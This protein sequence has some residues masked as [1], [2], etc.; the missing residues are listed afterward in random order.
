MLEIY[1]SIKNNK[2]YNS[3]IIFKNNNTINGSSL[4]D[5]NKYYFFEH[6]NNSEY[7]QIIFFRY[8]FSL[9]YKLIK[10]EYFIAFYDKDNNLIL[11]SDFSLYKNMNIICTTTNNNNV[12]DSLANIYKNKYFNCIEIF[13]INEKIKFGIKIIQTIKKKQILEHYF[14]EKLF[15]FNNLNYQ[16]NSPFDPLIINVEY[17]SLISKMN[18]K[19]FNQTLILKKSYMK[20]PSFSLKVEMSSFDN[21]W[22]FRNIYNHHFCFCKGNNCLNVKM[23]EKCKYNFYLYI[24]DINQKVYPKTEYLFMDFIFDELSSDDVYPIFEEMINQH[25]PA[26]YVT[27]KSNLY[28]KFC[29]NIKNC[30]IVL[31]VKQEKNPLNS[32]FLEKYLILFLKIKVVISGRGTTFNTNLFY[33]IEYI[34][35]ICVG[36]GVC[37]FK[38]FLYNNN[39][40]YGS[41]KSCSSSRYYYFYF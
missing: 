35:Y 7:Y 25:F 19:S 31:P 16:Y 37:Y 17:N 6:L 8:I 9:K 40:I 38:Y 14:D 13:K 30:L 32:N 12:Y 2:L 18:E 36:H 23:V 4:I 21:K 15:S 28:N 24:I 1:F 33:N 22:T 5:F 41:I 34:T 29:K 10:A 20:Y 3:K 26:H 11:P 39:R 27:E